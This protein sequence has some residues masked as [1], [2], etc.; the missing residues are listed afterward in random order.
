MIGK[1]L[2]VAVFLA[3]STNAWWCTGHMTVA[4][5]AKQTMSESAYE[6]VNSIAQSLSAS[7]PFPQ[8][9][10]FVQM[11]CWADDLKSQG[12]EPMAGWHFINQP[13]DP[14]NYPIAQWP[15]QEEN[16]EV[17]IAQL[18]K[19]LK[20]QSSTPA[21]DLAFALANLVHFY[22][23]IHQPLHA[24]ELFSSTYPTGDRGG[25]AQDVTV[26]GTSTKLHFVWDSIC[27]EYSQEL[28]RPLSDS[29]YATVQTFGQ[30]LQNT[31]TFSDSQAK[32]WNSTVMAQES[33]QDAIQY[34][35]PG[36]YSGMTISSAYLATCKPIAEGRVALAGVRLGNEL[37]Y[38]FG[39]SSRKPIDKMSD[40]E[41][42]AMAK[43][44]R[45]HVVR[46]HVRVQNLKEERKEELLALH[47]KLT[48]A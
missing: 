40:N 45:D 3:A 43:K 2:L 14:S 20:K 10:D 4:W 9:P 17:L 7:G 24:T 41:K 15:V 47:K 34:A 16:V 35:Y 18:D 38:L 37:E 11:A 46:S 44:I 8:S 30:Y 31:Y 48:K 29:D 22:G 32:E 19:T 39:D 27:W 13:Y 33:L 5:L 42:S 12:L 6:A 23:D 25:N 28:S 1:L 26:D 36:T 21:W